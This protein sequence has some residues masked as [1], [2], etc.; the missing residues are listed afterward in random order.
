MKFKIRCLIHGGS[1]RYFGKVTV[2]RYVKTSECPGCL[3]AAVRP[4]RTHTHTPRIVSCQVYVVIRSSFTSLFFIFHFHRKRGSM[5]T[6]SIIFADLHIA[7]CVFVYI[8]LSSA[9]KPT[10]CQNDSQGFLF[11]SIFFVVYFVLFFP[12]LIDW[13]WYCGF[14]SG[15]ISS[16]CFHIFSTFQ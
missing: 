14:I 16:G 15:F 4:R 10:W 3:C 11:H 1:I 9:P 13:F 7:R 12:H 5:C 6:T 2:S 8:R